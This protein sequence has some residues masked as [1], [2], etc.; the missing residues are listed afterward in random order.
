MREGSCGQ[1]RVGAGK[2][3]KPGVLAFIHWVTLDR[4]TQWFPLSRAKALSPKTD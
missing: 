4:L 3:G 2:V 1:K